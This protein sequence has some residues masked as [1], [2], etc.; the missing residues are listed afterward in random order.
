MNVG[1][2]ILFSKDKQ[3]LSRFL[4]DL[5]DLTPV[6]DDEAIR[7]LGSNLSFLILEREKLAFTGSSN[8]IDFFV[9]SEQ[10]LLAMHKKV[11]FIYYRY[12]ISEKLS[13]SEP[14]TPSIKE[15][16]EGKFF[17]ITDPDK[18][19]WKISFFPKLLAKGDS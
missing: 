18:R 16:L 5:F 2:I 13:D 8:I 10:E 15:S 3:L 14:A 1:Q 19:R 17:F 12:S 6:A 7:V 4:S 11:E 9:D